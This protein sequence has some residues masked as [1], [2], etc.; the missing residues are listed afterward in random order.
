M[1]EDNTYQAWTTVEYRPSAQTVPRSVSN[2]DGPEPVTRKPRTVGR[3][4][5]AN[6]ETLNSLNVS[7]DL[8]GHPEPG[9]RGGQGQA[10]RPAS[11]PLGDSGDNTEPGMVIDPVTTLVSRSSPVRSST[12]ITPP[13]MS[14]CHSCIGP[15]R[16]QRR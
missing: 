2:D 11:G 14:I 4:T 12:I 6:P 8:L 5:R 9:Q 3:T 10:H 15:G 7:Q 16:C 1:P 13:T